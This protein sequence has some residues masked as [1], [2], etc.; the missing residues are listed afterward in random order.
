MKNLNPFKLSLHSWVHLLAFVLI[1]LIIG[2][3]KEAIEGNENFITADLSVKSGD[4][5]VNTF[6]GPARHFGN[7]VVR[8]M[9]TMNHNGEPEAIGVKISEKALERL[10]DEIETITLRL[11]NKME[12]LPFDH[13]DLNWNPHGHEP[14]VVYGATHFDLH[15]YMISEE[16]KMQIGY[17]GAGDGIVIPEEVYQPE[18]YFPTM[19]VVPFM[20]MH[21]L[22]ALAPELGGADFTHTFIY[23]S[24]K[25]GTFI[26]YEPM[27]TLDYL[28][29]HA[30]G[31]LFEIS[32]PEEFQIS[33]FYYPTSY[34]MEYNAKKKE[35]IIVLEGLQWR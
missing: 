16:E 28:E 31:T 26:F 29:N 12:G 35:Y 15:F 9:V 13:I 22:N 1:F 14:E 32:Q 24:D 30:D 18:N 19:E 27:F 17:M 4:E 34:K 10:P 5:K 8:A 7:G 6:Y 2:C 11:P 23:G 25:D 21:W 20:G 3:E 33:G